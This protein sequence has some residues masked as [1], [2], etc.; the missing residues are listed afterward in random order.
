MARARAAW[1]WGMALAGLLLAAWGPPALAVGGGGEPPRDAARA[2]RWP[3]AAAEI[4]AEVNR[5]RASLGLGSLRASPDLDEIASAHSRDM[6]ARRRPSHDGFENRLDRTGASLCVENV[7]AGF[8]A[9]APLVAAWHA[10]P[11]H[12]RNLYEP[13]VSRVGIGSIDRFVTL[14][15]CD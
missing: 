2:P 4:L 10:A 15:A 11:A 6:A 7:A 1:Q 3:V 9:A 8:T 14:F 12:R 13:R 5:V